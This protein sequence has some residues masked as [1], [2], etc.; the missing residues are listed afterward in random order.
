MS[1]P[2][3]DTL[4]RPTTSSPIAASAA[5]VRV[6]GVHSRGGNA[7]N[8]TRSALLGGAA[9]A[10][11]TTGTKITMAQ[12]AAAAGVAKATLYNHFR[13]REAV[14]AALVV[15]QV[16]ALIDEQRG[17][18]LGVA[19]VD[20]ATALSAHPVRAGLAEVEPAVLAAVGRIDDVA[21]GW[22]HARTALDTALAAESRDGTDTVLRWLASYLLSPGDPESI[23]RDVAVLLAG[24]P[25][26]DGSSRKA[27]SPADE[28]V[29]VAQPA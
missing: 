24:L 8:R 10:V 4:F 25:V 27:T 22:Q 14:L 12:V 3:F 23:A 15:Q 13:T 6:K 18:P 28:T 20:A 5:P 21:E 7:M 2:L 11:A 17:K 16:D 1:D 9:R 26:V 29:A 19:L